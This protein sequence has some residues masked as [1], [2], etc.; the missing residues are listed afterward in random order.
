MMGM[1]VSYNL[2]KHSVGALNDQSSSREAERFRVFLELEIEEYF[3]RVKQNQ[4]K[5]P[6]G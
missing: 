6:R 3:T 2:G 1:F 5:N 4:N